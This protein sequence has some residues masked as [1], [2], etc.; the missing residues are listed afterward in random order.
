[1]LCNLTIP[2]VESSRTECGKG[3]PS[4]TATNGPG[5]PTFLLLTVPIQ[6]SAV[7][8]PG[9]HLEGGPFSASHMFLSCFFI[10]RKTLR[11]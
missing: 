11:V 2:K 6:S 5:G 1:M 8:S 7:D 4:A 3:G 10:V 9:D